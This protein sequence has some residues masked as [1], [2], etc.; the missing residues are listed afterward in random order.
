MLIIPLFVIKYLILNICQHIETNQSQKQQATGYTAYVTRAVFLMMGNSLIWLFTCSVVVIRECCSSTMMTEKFAI[1]KLNIF[2][3]EHIWIASRLQTHKVPLVSE[4]NRRSKLFESRKWTKTKSAELVFKL[5]QWS[6]NPSA[7]TLK[8]VSTCWI[9][10]LCTCS[11]LNQAI[12]KP[13]NLGKNIF[14]RDRQKSAFHPRHLGFLSW[15]MKRWIGIRIR[16]V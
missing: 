14:W 2:S 8:K 13:F 9:R 4:Q 3:F 10:P 12:Y 7:I 16:Q 11:Y 15:M 6:E 1:F 5:A